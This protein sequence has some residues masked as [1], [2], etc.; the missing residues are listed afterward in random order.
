MAAAMVAV[1]HRWCEIGEYV[2]DGVRDDTALNAS[3]KLNLHTN[4]APRS[5]K[6]VRLFELLKTLA[7]TKFTQTAFDLFAGDV[8]R[9]QIASIALNLGI[10]GI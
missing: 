1:M 10:A 7:D 9:T 2:L 8:E 3:D 5:H 4:K 6:I